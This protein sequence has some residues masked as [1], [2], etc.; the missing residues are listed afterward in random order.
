MI[1][2]VTASLFSRSV[3]FG[4]CFRPGLHAESILTSLTILP[5]NHFLV[6]L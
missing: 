6:L 2:R 5:A 4:F 3:H 1:R